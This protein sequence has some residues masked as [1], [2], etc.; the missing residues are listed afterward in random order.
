MRVVIVI[1]IV[2]QDMAFKYDFCV[3]MNK[4][5]TFSYIISSTKALQIR[6]AKQC[7]DVVLSRR[8]TTV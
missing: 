6:T 2:L 7:L 1:R 5:N 8:T 4:E 3:N